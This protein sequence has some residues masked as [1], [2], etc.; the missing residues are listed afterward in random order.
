[1]AVDAGGTKIGTVIPA[2]RTG[3]ATMCTSAAMIAVAIRPRLH[4][5]LAYKR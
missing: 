2:P 3:V 5:L 4:A 1:M